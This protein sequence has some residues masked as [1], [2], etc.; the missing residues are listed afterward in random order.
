MAQEETLLATV[1]PLGAP[2]LIAVGGWIFTYMNMRAHTA[3][4]ARLDRVNQQLRQLYGPLNALLESSDAAW[5]AFTSAYWPAH[6]Q[7]GYFAKGFETTDEEK[8]RWRLW[9]R[10][11]F[12]PTNAKMEDVITRNL[13]LVDGG[14]MPKAFVDALAH[15]SAYHAVLR[16]WDAGDYSE[17]TSVINF[18]SAALKAAVKP[19]YERLLREQAYLISSTQRKR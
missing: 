14:E 2:I 11:V 16:K 8:A 1:L 18:P 13:D 17:H 15:I 5:N 12:H 4:V 7:P 9:M 6:G 10:E 19:T 3:R